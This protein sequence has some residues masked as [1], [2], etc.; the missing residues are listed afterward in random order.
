MK[1]ILLNLLASFLALT[2]AL[3]ETK[4]TLLST[5]DIDQFEAFGGLSGVVAAERAA[6]GAV[7][8]LHAG[9]SYSPSI[10]AGLDQG[11]HM[12]DLL[13]EIAPDFMVVGNHEFDF[14]P[15]ALATNLANTTFPMLAGNVVTAT[16]AP[17]PNTQERA[18]VD[19]DGFKIGIFGLTTEETEAKSSVGDLDITDYRVATERHVAALR[20]QGAQLIIALGHLTFAEDWAL[21][22]T[23]LVDVLISG[24]DHNQLTFWNGRTALM[25][26]GEQGEVVTALDI[27]LRLD[28]RGDFHWS[29]AFR[30]IDSSAYHATPAV[31]AA[32]AVLQSKLSSE[33]AEVIG[34]TATQLNTTRPVIR[35]QEAAFGNL[36][37]DA[38]RAAMGT[39]IAMTA[40]GSIRAQKVYAPGTELTLGDVL[41]ELPFGNR[42][43]VLEVTGAQLLE[44]L[45]N[46]FSQVENNAGRFPHVSGMA[47]AVDFSAAPFSR[48]VSVTVGGVALDQGATYTVAIDEYLAGGGD[49][50][51]VL[52]AARVRA[53][54]SGATLV[55]NAL[56][57]YIRAAGTVAPVL[58]GRIS[59]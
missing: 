58:E 52:K 59:Q 48:V 31:G 7:L 32:I 20:A 24:D 9:D 25:E 15:E 1:R 50:Y 57:D 51:D 26:S 23:G 2:P 17:L 28:D 37:T 44:A 27:T 6:G 41:A 47:A 19:I 36:L 45:E 4:L 49:G 21:V 12:V 5:N 13:N 8:F 42:I 3:A 22:R 40:G 18:I 38:M 46:G 29:P 34:V 54:V 30:V 55:T 14:G 16:G 35:A 10:L 39:D 11:A 53:D 43:M 56:I 33:L